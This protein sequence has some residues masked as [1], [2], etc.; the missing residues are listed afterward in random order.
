MTNQVHNYVY[1]IEA[2]ASILG[3][4]ESSIKDQMNR[5]ELYSNQIDSNVVFNRSELFDRRYKSI[6]EQIKSLTI[7]YKSIPTFDDK[8]TIANGN[9]RQDIAEILAELER[10]VLSRELQG[11]QEVRIRHKEKEINI[12]CNIRYYNDN[13]KVIYFR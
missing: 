5:Q 3:L 8:L 4:P 2:A 7:M 9:Q 13:I 6:N 1:G 12:T 11:Y 10:S